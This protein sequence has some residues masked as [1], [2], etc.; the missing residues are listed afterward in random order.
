M[1]K[2]ITHLAFILLLLVA[3]SAGFYF[4]PRILADG[5][6]IVRGYE[7]NTQV[8]IGE[9]TRQ[10]ETVIGPDA[11]FSVR[12]GENLRV[13]VSRQGHYPWLKHV[14]VPDTKKIQIYPFLVPVQA[15]GYLVE[16][17][18][19]EYERALKIFDNDFIPRK[20]TPKKKGSTSIWVEEDGKTVFAEWEGPDGSEPRHFCRQEQGGCQD[21]VKIFSFVNSVRSVDFY[22]DR[23]DVVL[24]A[25]ETADGTSG[26]FALEIDN[27]TVQNFQPV[28]TGSN[29]S[30]AI[31]DQKTIY[32]R[33]G[34][35]ILRAEP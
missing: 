21:T 5:N 34:Q 31:L 28:Y 8:T 17:D 26:I 20:N 27:R 9:E 7:Q 16:K 10:P 25:T 11:Y 6:L 29:P 13:L 32:I 35:N 15:M 1:K 24:I 30:F 18:G 33:D 23:E 14:D 12:P 4:L 19:R 2:K 22:K 3:I